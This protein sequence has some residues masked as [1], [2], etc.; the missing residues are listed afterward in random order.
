MISQISFQTLLAL[1]VTL[2]LMS[3]RLHQGMGLVLNPSIQ[4]FCYC[5]SAY[6]PTLNLR[7][8]YQLHCFGKVPIHF[9]LHSNLLFQ[10]SILKLMPFCL[11]HHDWQMAT[12]R[13]SVNSPTHF[14]KSLN[15]REFDY[16]SASFLNLRILSFLRSLALYDFK[17]PLTQVSP[18]YSVTYT[19][20]MAYCVFLKAFWYAF[21][22]CWSVAVD[23]QFVK[24]LQLFICP[25]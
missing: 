6:F 5:L 12:L 13:N 7:P 24:K 4:N 21:F 18:W 16:F 3:L 2:F 10:F 19:H 25:F 9:L 8:N 15:F 1:G 20:Q 22:R 14:L 17:T 11:D 23:K